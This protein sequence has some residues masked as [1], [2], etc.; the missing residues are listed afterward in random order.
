MSDIRSDDAFMRPLERC[1]IPNEGF[2]HRDHIRAAW[3][4]VKRY[5]LHEAAATMDALIKRFAAHHGHGDKYHRTLTLLWVRLVAAHAAACPERTFDGFARKNQALLDKHLP[6][7]FYRREAL[8]SPL[9][10]AQWVDADLRPLPA[11]P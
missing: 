3:W 7:H 6:L 2:H 1:T 4:C 8:F 9:A 5:P 10:R 11:I